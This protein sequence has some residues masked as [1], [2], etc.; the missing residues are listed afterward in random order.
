MLS[1]WVHS[2]MLQSIGWQRVGHDLATEQQQLHWGCLLLPC[3]PHHQYRWP[4]RGRHDNSVDGRVSEKLVTPEGSSPGTS[5]SRDLHDRGSGG[6]GS[7]VPWVLVAFCGQ[8]SRSLVP[9]SSRASGLH[10]F[11]LICL[12]LLPPCRKMTKIFTGVNNFLL[13]ESLEGD[14]A[15]GDWSE[16]FLFSMVKSRRLGF[17]ADSHWMGR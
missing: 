12:H 16:L 13:W 17:Y 7:R 5:N 8:R 15:I 2:D 10:F 6:C 3:F 11:E 1:P 9:A 4:G 14:Q